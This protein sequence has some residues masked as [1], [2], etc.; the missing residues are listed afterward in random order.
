MNLSN[1]KINQLILGLLLATISNGQVASN[2]PPGFPNPGNIS[3]TINGR[4]KAIQLPVYTMASD[5]MKF[6]FNSGNCVK[7]GGNLNQNAAIGIKIYGPGRR[8]PYLEAIAKSNFSFTFARPYSAINYTEPFIVVVSNLAGKSAIS[9]QIMAEYCNS[10]NTNAISNC[11]FV[12]RNHLTNSNNN[13]VNATTPPADMPGRLIPSIITLIHGK[14]ATIENDTRANN[15]RIEG[16]NTYAYTRFYWGFDFIR[17]LLGTTNDYFYTYTGLKVTKDMWY[18]EKNLI[19]SVNENLMLCAN[20]PNSTAPPEKSVMILFRD[21]S[22]DLNTQGKETVK[23]IFNIYRQTWIAKNWKEQ[24]DF[25]LVGHSMGGIVAR[26]ILRQD[27]KRLELNKSFDGGL[28]KRELT[29]IKQPEN[30]VYT[31]ALTE[32]EQRLFI[33]DNTR[34]LVTLASPHLGSEALVKGSVIM[35]MYNNQF[36]PTIT[37]FIS[38]QCN[39]I[40]I[41]DLKNSCNQSLL[42]LAKNILADIGRELADLTGTAGNAALELV[43]PKMI[44]YNNGLLN[45]TRLKRSDNTAIPVYS[46]SGHTP[47]MDIFNNNISI[48]LIATDEPTAAVAGYLVWNLFDFYFNF[49]VPALDIE[50]QAGTASL[51]NPNTTAIRIP[52]TILDHE[53]ASLTMGVCLNRFKLDALKLVIADG[54]THFNMGSNVVSSWGAPASPDQDIVARLPYPPSISLVGALLQLVGANYQNGFKDNENDADGLVGFNS[55][56]NS[57][58]ALPLNYDHINKGSW[59]KVHSDPLFKKN[60]MFFPWDLDNHR[61][62]CFNPTLASWLN[63]NLFSKAGKYPEVQSIS[64]W[65]K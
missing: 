56:M 7:I 4:I 5:T 29:E 34:Y 22:L 50:L 35:N 48:L 20:F 39:K 62:I 9:G 51:S 23:Q 21:G 42:P 59:Y 46:L 28:V 40:Y 14:T 43:P 31:N 54:V 30:I 45:P 41:D 12:G 60:G 17:N 19:P 44:D 15:T 49:S 18:G 3:A 8:T 55:G 65:T 63:L 61:N 32:E 10:G 58:S 53:V 27:L 26:W 24:P 57:T 47:D 13:P 38:D 36:K 33:R 16:V 37:N 25:I 64:K 6:N 52:I 2:K 11:A 1:I